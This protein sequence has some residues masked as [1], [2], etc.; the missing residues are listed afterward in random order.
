MDLIGLDFSI[1]KPAAT[2]FH[3]DMYYFMS[4]PYGLP[5]KVAAVYENSGVRI[6]KR[7]DDKIKGDNISEQM[8]Y[9]IKNSVYLAKLIFDSLLQYLDKDTII[10]FEGLSYAS[11]GD[12]VLQLGGY[13]YMLMNELSK[14][15]P[16]KNM[17][18]YSPQTVKS[19]AGCA[20]RGMGKK[21]MIEAFISKGPHCIFNH[22]IKENKMLFTKKGRN[23]NINFIEHLDD[24][25]DSYWVLETMRVKQSI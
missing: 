1:N 16:L 10:G 12:V 7:T 8:R 23:G 6:I 2:I 22:E 25:C 5:D 3:N 20:K 21:E 13:K 18:T 24:V 11:S 4:W 17:F 14:K 9:Q 15:V 19:I